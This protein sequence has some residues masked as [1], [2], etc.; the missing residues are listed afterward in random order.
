MF[1]ERCEDLLDLQR[2]QPVRLGVVD[3]AVCDLQGARDGNAVFGVMSCCERAPPIVT[4]LNT[5]PGSKASVTAWS[6]VRSCAV[7]VRVGVRV[8]A[9]LLRHGEDRAR[10]RVED[11]GRRVLRVPLLDRLLEHLLGVRLDVAV[12]REEDVAAV[13]GRALL[14]R[15]HGRPSASAHDRR[16]ARACPQLPVRAG[17]RAPR[18][19]CCRPR[20]RAPAPRPSPAGRRA[21]R[22]GQKVKPRGG[23]SRARPRASAA[24]CAGRRRSSAAGRAAAGTAARNGIPSTFAAIAAPA[25]GSAICIGSA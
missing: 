6:T 11:D 14:D 4:T 19:R 20:S 15:V 9:R 22:S 17:A 8:V 10:V 12:E 24:P 23:A 18:G 7:A 13:A 5:E 1:E 25:R 21:S 2:L 16:A 3:H